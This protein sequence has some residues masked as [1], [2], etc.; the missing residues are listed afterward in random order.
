MANKYIAFSHFTIALVVLGSGSRP[1]NMRDLPSDKICDKYSPFFVS[2]G[3][4]YLTWMFLIHYVEAENQTEI[5]VQNGT[6]LVEL[7]CLGLPPNATSL[8]WGRYDSGKFL[9]LVDYTWNE[10]FSVSVFHEHNVD[11][12]SLN[13]TSL[14][15]SNVS[16]ADV[17]VYICNSSDHSYLFY[18]KLAFTG[19]Q[20]YRILTFI[21]VSNFISNRSVRLLSL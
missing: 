18:I 14:M 5:V 17:G 15:I 13:G 16:L 12:Y 4:I 9:Q 3:V 8:T 6:F 19:I 7:Q 21:S 20:F 11:K 2:E 10:T 1:F